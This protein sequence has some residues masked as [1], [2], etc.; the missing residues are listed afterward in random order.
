[1]IQHTYILD[2]NVYGELLIEPNTDE[3]VRKIRRNKSFFIYGVD[4]IELELSE[5]PLHMKYKG[6][7]TRKLL[8]ELFESLSDE[9]ITVN[10][11][12]K[13]LAEGYLKKYKE[14]AKS[15]KYKITKE[16]YDEESLKTDFEIIAIASIRGIDIVVSLD[17]RTLL[18]HL[19]KDV[20]MHINSINGLRTPKLIEYERFKEV[21]LK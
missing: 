10:P 20:Y 15:G 1:M 14:S 21:Y 11:L 16:K 5:T 4:V 18:S 13:Y 6:K 19:A 12:A 3:L 9:I 8:I 7:T 2:T 17:K